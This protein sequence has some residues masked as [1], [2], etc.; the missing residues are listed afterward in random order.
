[1]TPDIT[2]TIFLKALSFVNQTNKHLFI[3]GKAGT[4]KTTFLKYIKENS[5]KKM[6]V[7]A[8]TGVAAI[9]AGGM[10]I[11]SFFQLPMGLFLPLDGG[12]WNNYSSE[13]HN[14][15]TL[16]KNLRLRNDKREVL[17][18]LDLLVIDEIS[19]VR[20]D[21]LDAIDTVM[22]HVR[23]QP[24]IPF[25]GVQMVYIG[26]LFQLPPV[27][28]Q[29]DWGILE[30][31]YKSPFFFDA[32]A[33]QMATPL[34]IEL[35]KMYRQKD[36][37][38]I[39]ILNNVRNNCCTSEDLERL[40]L[41]Y[42]STFTPAKK[43][44]YITL[45]SHNARADTINQNEL[46]KLPGK[47]FIY[48]AQI[49]GEFYDRS[50]PAEKELRL[51]IGAQIMF[52]KNDKGEARRFYNGKI[53][54]VT[55]LEKDK[56]TVTFPNEPDELELELEKWENIR[57]SYDQQKDNLNQEELGTFTQYPIRL[58]W[59]ITIH[60]SQGL[61]FERAIVDAGASFAA[62]QVYV[63]LSRL[64]SLEG[65]VLHS[66]ILPNSISTDSRVIDYVQA[67]KA[68]DELQQI[69]ESEQK[70][71]VQHYLLQS[72]SWQKITDVVQDNLEAYEHRQFPDKAASVKWAIE[73]TEQSN[74]LMEVAEKFTRQLDYLC[75][76]CEEDKYKTLYERTAAA[77]NYF[78]TAMDENLISCTQKHI[79]KVNLKQ[80]VKRYVKELQSMMVFFKRKKDQILQALQLAEALRQSV[81][82]EDLLKMVKK[83]D[84]E[85][86]IVVSP[87]EH[88]ELKKEK[89]EKGESKR[90]SLQMFKN[91]HSI[92]DIATER[93]MS[94]GTIE[95][96]LASFIPTGEVDVLDLVDATNMNIVVKIMK[97]NPEIK[98]A[99]IKQIAGES[100]SFSDIRAVAAYVNLTNKEVLA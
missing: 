36:D 3:T 35:K 72:F 1:M 8:P 100:V 23:R 46:N 62:G 18:Q 81:D 38:F 66:R 14:R 76:T 60:K 21:L 89:K 52:I 24:L 53:G 99:E 69:L 9:N 11:H 20:A 93:G 87:D 17:R 41:Q 51:K 2:N 39:N 31:Y 32:K 63:S 29:E 84:E 19:M 50:F 80:K 86:G 42:D 92:A 97:E 98:H 7:I 58:A 82:I 74:K 77:C 45:T 40:H 57:Y 12:G 22:R 64:T 6:A 67:E 83:K 47:P 68:E 27:A 37:V 79:N 73:L 96:H 70:L 95:T 78:I 90:I 5:H 54:T 91:G 15:S 13:V 94:S 61:T 48:V 30:Q 75:K 59:A 88:N 34:Y 85:K 49:T 4:G 33:L 28:R 43:E 65:L 25:G 16:L 44:N 55:N 26:D 10:T 56:I 71:Y